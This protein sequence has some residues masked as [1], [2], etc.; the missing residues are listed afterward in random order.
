MAR[1]SRVGFWNT[2]GLVF[3]WNRLCRE[4]LLVFI[5]GRDT[6]WGGCRRVLNLRF[7]LRCSW[8]RWWRCKRLESEG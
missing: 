3:V 2:L 8:Q 4:D 6:F 5:L 7:G 1:L